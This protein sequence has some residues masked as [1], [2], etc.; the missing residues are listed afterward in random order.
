MALT[1]TEMPVKTHW[2]SGWKTLQTVAFTVG[3]AAGVPAGALGAIAWGLWSNQA[4]YSAMEAKYVEAI[5]SN[6]ALATRV[7]A[8]EEVNKAWSAERSVLRIAFNDRLTKLETMISPV[9]VTS[10]VISNYG[11]HL[12]G[13]D[14]AVKVT[15]D[16]LLDEQKIRAA[17]ITGLC[18]K[19]AGIIGASGK[20]PLTCP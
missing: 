19:L 14:A 12:G 18:A 4:T 7:N 8:L 15:N 5:A 6:S 16:D 3:W 2:W 1:E 17:Q 9:V 20:H 13:L 11:A 10:D